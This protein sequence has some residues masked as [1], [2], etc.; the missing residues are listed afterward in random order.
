MNTRGKWALHSISHFI[1][2][3]ARNNSQLDHSVNSEA[4]L[5]EFKET[6]GALTSTPNFDKT[7]VLSLST[8]PVT[9]ITTRL[10]G[11]RDYSRL[12]A[13]ASTVAFVRSASVWV[14]LE[15]PKR[16]TMELFEFVCGIE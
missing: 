15:R 3:L 8:T 4:S 5:P 11:H 9:M 14:G 7:S 16:A 1:L 2:P 10:V 6:I 12:K 13:Q